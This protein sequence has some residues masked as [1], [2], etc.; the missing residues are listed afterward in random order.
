MPKYK[1]HDF[2]K[3]LKEYNKQ[4]KKSGTLCSDISE[5]TIIHNLENNRFEVA[6]TDGYDIRCKKSLIDFL[7]FHILSNPEIK[8][9]KEFILDKEKG[10]LNLKI[11]IWPP[12]KIRYAYLGTNYFSGGG[13]LGRSCMRHKTS[14]KSLNFYIKNNVK[15]VVVTDNSNKIHARALLWEGVKSEKLKNPFTY[16]DRVYTI[17]DSLVSLFYDLAEEN[18]WKQYKGVSQGNAAKYLYIDNLDIIGMCHMPWVDT[19]KHLYYKDSLASSS[20]MSN[21][22]HSSSVVTLTHTEGAVGGV[23]ISELDPDKIKEVIS[24]NYMSKKDAV[25][26]KRYEGYVLK[27]NIADIDGTY[28]STLDNLVVKTTID[29]YI[30]KE[31]SVNEVFTND[32]IDKSKAIKSPKYEGYI[33][34]FNAINIKGEIYHKSDDNVVGFGNKWYHISQCFINYNRE[35]VNKEIVEYQT[36]LHNSLPEVWPFWA[37]INVIATR[38]GSLI[39]KEHAIIAYNLIYN[40]A[41]DELLY[42]ERYYTKRTGLIKLTTGEFIVD[43]SNN[44]KYL[45][46]FNNK[47]YIKQ[48]FEAPNKNQLR[49]AFM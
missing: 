40:P 24:G 32:I 33:H 37:Y 44:R 28:Y 39:P 47:Y 6:F 16:L 7:Y 17:S 27:E 9:F 41:L 5:V 42:Q 21:V 18:H 2:I 11:K 1:N 45:K 3:I 30:L 14:Q 8:S 23:Y 46:K 48:D 4:Y 15:I 49:F 31:N 22:K 10:D 12:N 43:T 35:E 20:T 38:E 13:N 26:V 29:G 34:K 19:F 25:F 36:I